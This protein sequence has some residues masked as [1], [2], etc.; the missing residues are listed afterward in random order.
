VCLKHP[1]AQSFISYEC[2]FKYI[3][4]LHTK[5]I[6]LKQSPFISNFSTN[7]PI[8]NRQLALELQAFLHNYNY[9]QVSK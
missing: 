1:T 9:R 8:Q 6:V 7:N 5:Q 3:Y 2:I 4:L